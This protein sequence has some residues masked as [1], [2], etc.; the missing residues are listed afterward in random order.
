MTIS[1][2]RELGKRIIC[3]DTKEIIG[4]D[5]KFLLAL[6]ALKIKLS[7]TDMVIFGC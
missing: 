1:I 5:R 6:K 4:Q 2:E 7:Q 3:N